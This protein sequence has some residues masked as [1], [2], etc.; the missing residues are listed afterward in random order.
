MLI[1]IPIY[2]SRSQSHR[3]AVQEATKITWPSC[4]CGCSRLLPVL[5]RSATPTCITGT[6]SAAEAPTAARSGA[7]QSCTRVAAC[8]CAPGLPES[9]LGPGLAGTAGRPQ[10]PAAPPPRSQTL[11]ARRDCRVAAASRSRRPS[12]RVCDEVAREGVGR[13]EVSWA[14]SWTSAVKKITSWAVS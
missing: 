14:V 13:W 4:L 1:E 8:A 12:S 11:A 7:A 5:R 10:Q 2:N 3:A 9:L 6:P